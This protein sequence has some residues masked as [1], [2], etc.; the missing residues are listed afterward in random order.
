MSRVG[1]KRAGAVYSFECTACGKC[2]NSGPQLSLP[3]LFH[4]Q[5]RFLGTL[6]MRRVRGAGPYLHA[7]GADESLQLVLQ[8]HY[9]PDASCPALV[10]DKC[11]VHS[12]RK[13]AQCS[14]VPLDAWLPDA[15][16]HLVLAGRVREAFADCIQTGEG[17]TLVRQLKVVQTDAA[18]AL[19]LRRADLR[20]ERAYWGDAVFASLRAD[21]ASLLRI[22]RTGFVAIPPA[23]VLAVIATVSEPCRARCLE[24]LEA[25]LALN[26]GGTPELVALARTSQVLLS[27]LPWVVGHPRAAEIEAWLGL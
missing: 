5:R 11:D 27:K 8:A 26:P 22:P 14:V 20:L 9:D 16:Q 7:L 2:C 6:A 4:H 18:R 3:E 15:Q 23:P 19:E 10:G 1:A 24:F 17:K 13:P 25:Q 12:D 21:T